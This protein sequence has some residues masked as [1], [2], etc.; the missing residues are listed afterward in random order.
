MTDATYERRTQSDAS[1]HRIHAVM[2][3]VLSYVRPREN[4]F[5]KDEGDAEPAG[6]ER[7]HRLVERRLALRGHL[8]E[9]LLVVA[10]SVPVVGGAP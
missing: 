3:A 8:A 4:V 5:E 9:V 1:A 10:K 7:E 2:S 6:R